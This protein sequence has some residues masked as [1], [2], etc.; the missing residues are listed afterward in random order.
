MSD[1]RAKSALEPIEG[2]A[3]KKELLKLTEAL[4]A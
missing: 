2:S 1:E 4:T 3:A